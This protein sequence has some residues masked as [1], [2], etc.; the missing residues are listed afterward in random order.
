M[1]IAYKVNV[2]IPAEEAQTLYEAAG[3]PRPKQLERIALMLRHANVLITAWD[4][5][6]LVGLLRAMTDFAFDCY[7]NDLAVHKEYQRQGIGQELLS[8]LTSMLPDEVLLFLL[9]APDAV[10]FYARMGLQSVKRVED[11]WYMVTG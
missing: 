11:V 8:Q 3:L 2:P 9:A 7:L 10:P 6:R 5:D 4:G 1:P